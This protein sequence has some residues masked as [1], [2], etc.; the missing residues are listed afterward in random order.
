MGRRRLA[1]RRWG[2]ADCWLTAGPAAAWF[3]LAGCSALRSSPTR[4]LTLTPHRYRYYVL[5]AVREAQRGGAWRGGDERHRAAP[6]R[7]TCT[8]N[9]CTVTRPAASAETSSRATRTGVD[10]V[11]DSGRA[12]RLQRAVEPKSRRGQTAPDRLCRN[13]RLMTGDDWCAWA[14]SK[15][16]AP[17]G[18]RTHTGKERGLRGYRRRRD[19][20]R[21]RLRAARSLP[22]ERDCAS[23]RCCACLGSARRFADH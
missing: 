10:G 9:C 15:P 11:L 16:S 17:G 3:G 5:R 14:G 13:P 23:L 7:C 1:G 18:L 20:L 4:S 19:P 6:T 22:A 12:L 21:L 8:A 2:L